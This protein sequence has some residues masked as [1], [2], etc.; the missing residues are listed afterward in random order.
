[1]TSFAE[2]NDMQLLASSPYVSPMCSIGNLEMFYP[3]NFLVICTH[4]GS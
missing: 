4:M 2:Y 3:M 1:M